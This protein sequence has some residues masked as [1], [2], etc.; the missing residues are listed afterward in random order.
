M[1]NDN[2]S[3]SCTI[4]EY[5]EK[6]KFDIFMHVCMLDY[7]GSNRIDRILNVQ[8]VCRQ[9]SDLSQ[10]R[11]NNGKVFTDK[12]DKLFDKYISLAV[13][14]P[15][16]AAIWPIQL[17]SAYLSALTSGLATDMTDEAPFIMPDLT[18][19]RTKLLQIAI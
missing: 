18:T 19:L 2:L 17:Y 8:E 7:V 4:Q 15:D 1:S 12:P 6:C 3:T 14:W 11:S 16:D 9:V 10:V 13:N 5:A